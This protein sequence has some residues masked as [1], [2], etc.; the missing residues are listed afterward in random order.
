M[1]TFIGVDAAKALL[2]FVLITGAALY[3]VVTS[4]TLYSAA[5]EPIPQSAPPTEFSS[6]RALEHIVEKGYRPI[7]AHPE[8]YNGFAITR[9]ELDIPVNIHCSV[10]FST[11][12]AMSAPFSAIAH[13]RYA[14]LGRASASATGTA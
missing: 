14:R 4:S 3:G 13:T 12:T 11:A 5:P 9:I 8:R 1:K 7:V 6:A 10:N 2:M